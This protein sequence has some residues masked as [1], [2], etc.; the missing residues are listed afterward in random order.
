MI[1]AD[2]VAGFEIVAREDFSDATYSLIVRHS[3]MAKA[4][5]PGQFAIVMLHE[6]GERIPLMIADFDCPVQ[7][8][9]DAR[10]MASCDLKNNT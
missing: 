2:Q 1:G 6:T 9:M 10:R 8:T 7:L 4:A 3:W 5:R